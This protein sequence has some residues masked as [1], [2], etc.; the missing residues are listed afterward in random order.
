MCD[1]L[2]HVD[3]ERVNAEVRGRVTELCAQFPVYGT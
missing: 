3:D 1:V 2:E